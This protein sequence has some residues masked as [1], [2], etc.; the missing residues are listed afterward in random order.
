[1]NLFMNKEQAM[2]WQ[3]RTILFEFQKDGLLGDKY[4]D[5]EEVEILL[6]EQGAGGWELVNVTMI[7][8]GLLAF[9]KRT[10]IT[11]QSE[12][13]LEETLRPV[14]TNSQMADSEEPVN[15]EELQQQE[16]EHIQRLEEQRRQTMSAIEKDT[17]GEIK[18]S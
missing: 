14:V 9:C 18:I 8:E 2:Q 16:R 17:V 5:D 3:Y 1:M 6:N 13:R 10:V 15:A 7:Q 4:I 11:T 12:V